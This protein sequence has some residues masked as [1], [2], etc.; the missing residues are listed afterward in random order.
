MNQKN[1]EN[2]IDFLK[3]E[4]HS[5]KVNF[6]SKEIFQIMNYI[7]ICKNTD[8]FVKLEEKLNDDYPRL[9]EY[10]INFEINGRKLKRFKTLDENN[11]KNDDIINLILIENI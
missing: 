6:V 3:S 9:R 5:L 2:K 7:L 4:E 11:L 10:D 1:V 8:I